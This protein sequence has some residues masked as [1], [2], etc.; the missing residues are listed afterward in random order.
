MDALDVRDFLQWLKHYDHHNGGA[1][2]VGND[3]TRTV[4]CILS[5]ALRHYQGYIVVHAEG[6]GVVNH[7][8]TILCDGLSKFLRRAGTSRGEG[9]VDILEI[10]VMLEQL[11]CQ[12]LTAEGVFR[13]C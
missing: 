3:T 4:Q 7:H 5:V 10:V 13:A 1:V 11:H 8:S 12:L 9:D 6:T 2:G